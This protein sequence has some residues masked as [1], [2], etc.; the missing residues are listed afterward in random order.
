[1][2]LLDVCVDMDHVL[3]YISNRKLTTLCDLGL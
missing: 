3:V 2:E 1:M